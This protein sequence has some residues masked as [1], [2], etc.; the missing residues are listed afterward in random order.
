MKSACVFDRGEQGGVAECQPRGGATQE[1]LLVL[2]FIF[3]F[4]QCI[5]TQPALSHSEKLFGLLLNQTYTAQSVIFQGYCR[6]LFRCSA[7]VGSTGRINMSDKHC[8]LCVGSS[9]LC[10]DTS[11]T[12]N[13]HIHLS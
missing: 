7:A 5:P 4:R 12:V 9:I 2:F 1:L 3:F 8:F 10:R 11:F 13:M 6:C